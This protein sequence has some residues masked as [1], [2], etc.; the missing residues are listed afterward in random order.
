MMQSHNTP[1]VFV[2]TSRDLYVDVMRY[3]KGSRLATIQAIDDDAD[4]LEFSIQPASVNNHD[5]QPYFTINRTSGELRLSNRQVPYHMPHGTAQSLADVARNRSLNA[6]ANSLGDAADVSVSA[7][8]PQTEDHLGK[9]I[10]LLNVAANDGHY[11]SV[12]ELHIHVINSSAI[13]TGAGGPPIQLTPDGGRRASEQI[14]LLVNRKTQE[15]YS[16]LQQINDH[17][18]D[19]ANLNA[20]TSLIY[21]NFV[22]P[23][24]VRPDQPVTE[25]PASA[26]ESAFNVDLKE[27]YAS[28][29]AYPLRSEV[30][31]GQFE[32]NSNPV[33][34]MDGSTTNRIE[35]NPLESAI[36]AQPML[37]SLVIAC[38]F[39][40]IALVLL[41][42]IV[43]LS[44]KRLR[45]RIKQ[46]EHVHHEQLSQRNSNG[47]TLCSSSPGSVSTQT[48]HNLA[49]SMSQFTLGSS[50]SCVTNGSSVCR[51][52]SIDSSLGSSRHLSPDSRAPALIDR[53]MSG[54][55]NRLNNGSIVNPMYLQQ[56][57]QLVQNLVCEPSQ[58]HIDQGPCLF[59]SSSQPLSAQL[60]VGFEQLDSGH[61][62]YHPLDDEQPDEFYSTINGDSSSFN[63]HYPFHQVDQDNKR[64]SIVESSHYNMAE[65]EPPLACE[66]SVE[67]PNGSESTVSST[68]SLAKFLSLPARHFSQSNQRQQ[69]GLASKS[70]LED[71]QE[72][73]FNLE[74][75]IS[76][77]HKTIAR[78]SNIMREQQQL[79]KS[80]VWELERH[81]ILPI[82]IIGE[83][84]FGQ[85]WMYKLL[86]RSEFTNDQIV[87]VKMLRADA[88]K[89]Q[90]SRE[91]LLAEIEIMKQLYQHPNVVKILYCCTKDS[92]SIANARLSSSSNNPILLVME[93]LELGKL[94]SF[95]KTSRLNHQYATA[96][97]L[98]GPQSCS[99][100]HL[101]SRDLVK[102]IYHVA[103]GME[104]VSAHC[105]VHRDLASRNILVSSKRICKI[106]DF[107]MA[108]QMQSPSGIY[109]RRSGN[110][111]IP[112]RW[113]APEVL[114]S[115]VY[116]SKSDVFSFGI[117]MWEIVT[118]A[119]TPY[120]QLET[121]QVIRE[122]ANNG[123]RP[124]RPKYCHSQLYRIMS[125]CWSTNP[126]D[127][128]TFKDLVSQLDKMLLSSN[129]YIELDQY[130]DHNYYNIAKTSAPNELL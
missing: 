125:Q 47:S 107:G 59:Q 82:K 108:R 78:D 91:D 122:V 41:M 35:L 18:S 8:Q 45:K 98:Q 66:R 123:L 71:K 51:Q 33:A 84:Q 39:L 65:C 49:S 117:L 11:T 101:T 7:N 3:T 94:Q 97:V 36:R 89:D 6:D 29:A 110:T 92:I 15:Y 22:N 20:S 127:R 119:S 57:Q 103:K 10:Y 30:L 79:S 102:F 115:N 58:V 19:E 2:T 77:P 129:D 27:A 12:L 16:K 95:L 86:A 128:P 73:P 75:L 56:R 42:F 88:N 44:V 120:R 34:S 64:D 28:T 93:Y 113:M 26:Q 53:L 83:G 48:N 130:P 69:S 37:V 85:V 60:A 87:A 61:N 62:I 1:P 9:N 106:G 55:L 5:A 50:A 31:G 90:R 114:L 104:Y 4:K 54:H 76:Y 99:D 105:I 14:E 23:A 109:E 17:S 124:E 40:T 63:Q 21:P 80:R 70:N 68:R 74:Q 32:S 43:P 81:K 24:L 38:S 126:E 100:Y 46:M 25:P 121:S 111:K 72:D 116:T 13:Q 52:S 96:N 118:L 112:V 67:S